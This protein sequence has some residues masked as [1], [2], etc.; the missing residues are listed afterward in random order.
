MERFSRNQ[1]PVAKPASGQTPARSSAPSGGSSNWQA[2]SWAAKSLVLVVIVSGLVVL[3]ALAGIAFTNVES[4][5]DLVKEDRYQAVFLDNGQVYFG[6]LSD[7]NKDYVVLQDIY[8]LQVNQPVQPEQ[9]AEGE[10]PA[11][12]P[13]QQAQISLAKL[14]NELHGPEDVMYIQHDKIIFWE[15]LKTEGQVTTAIVDFVNNQD[16]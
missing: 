8:Y 12:Q 7:T 15:N 13:E 4:S 5:D 2:P 1:G 6:K 3:G 10:D 16:Q 14:G 9:V 11:E